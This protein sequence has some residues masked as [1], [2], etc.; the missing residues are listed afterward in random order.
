MQLESK[1]VWNQTNRLGKSVLALPFQ[2]LSLS[3]Y[4]LISP[5][6]MKLRICTPDLFTGSTSVRAFHA[7]NSTSLYIAR[8]YWTLLV[9]AL[10]RV[11]CLKS[12]ELFCNEFLWNFE[13]LLVR[14]CVHLFEKKQNFCVSPIWFLLHC[15]AIRFWPIYCVDAMSCVDKVALLLIH[16][17]LL[18][19]N[20]CRSKLHG[21]GVPLGVPLRKLVLT[22]Q[23]TASTHPHLGVV[24]A[25]TADIM[26][27][28]LSTDAP[29]LSAKN[30]LVHI[31][32]C[33]CQGVFFFF[34]LFSLPLSCLSCKVLLV[35]TQC[36]CK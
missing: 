1:D 36:A 12:R 27:S 7:Y 5:Q 21:N 2:T 29:D 31:S 18:V 3:F 11:A 17:V 32:R 10:C 34:F 23:V 30:M 33:C 25:C 4:F 26:F 9:H 6:T 16:D 24:L 28:F 19:G 22:S 13:E 20:V 15:H 35:F 14:C 8:Q